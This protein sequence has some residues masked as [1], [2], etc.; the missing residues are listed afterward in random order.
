[1]I[2]S[3]WWSVFACIRPLSPGPD[4]G[5]CAET[6]TGVFRYGEP[7]IGTCLA[8]PSELQFFGQDGG[9]FLAV[10]NTDPYRN[11]RS[12]SVL[13]LDWDDLAARIDGGTD[14][15]IPMDELRSYPLEIRQDDD[16]DGYADNPFLGGFA[17]LPGS[18]IAVV[19]SRLSENGVLR[20]GR[21]EA[22]LL[23]L[24]RMELPGG[25]LEVAGTLRLEDDPMPAVADPAT[26][27]VFVGNL[28]D[29]S[30]SVLSS[31]TDGPLPLVEIDVAPE[32]GAGPAR[33]TDADGDGS[34]AEMTRLAVAT[35]EDLKD[36]AF[37]LTYVD[38]TSRL[39]VPT[40]V[41]G[42]EEVVGLRR[43]TSGG[44]PF[45]PT[46]FGLD[47]FY[48]DTGENGFGGTIGEPFVEVDEAGL[49][50]LWFSRPDGTIWRALQST[51]AGTWVVEATAVRSFGGVHRAPSAAPLDEGVGL[52]TER[53]GADGA[54]EIW[55]AVAPDGVSFS[56]E[57]AVL[58]PPP[59]VSFEQPFAVYDASVQRWRMWLTVHDGDAFSV[60]LSES[61]DGRTWS[62]P[63]EVLRE[64]RPVA[65]PTVA[66]LDGRY[67]M[68]TTTGPGDG[69]WSHA[70]S[71]SYD[72]VAWTSPEVVAPSDVVADRP[73]RAGAQTQVT[74]AWRLTAD[75][76]GSLDALLPAGL[77]APVELVGLELMVSSGHEVANRAS[78]GARPPPV[79]SARSAQTDGRGGHRVYATAYDAAGKGRVV[80]F[81]VDDPG[82][83]EAGDER[84]AWS[85]LVDGTDLRADLDLK[86]A[87]T[88]TDPV[89]V[90]D[91]DGWV[92]FATLNDRS[93]ARIVRLDTDD[94]LTFGPLD[95][96]PVIRGDSDGGWD[97]AGQ[98][99]A[100]VE[101]RG[102]EIHLWY[103]GDDG[104]RR[105][106][107]S[108]VAPTLRD[109]FVRERGLSDE[110][111]F[112]TGLPGS[113]DDTSVA[114]PLV[115]RVGEEVHLWYSG[116]D[117]LSWH[118][119]H[120]V[121]DRRGQ[122]QRRI[123]PASQLSVPAM[124]GQPRSF[125]SL[126]VR[127]PVLLSQDEGG[128]VLLYTG[129][130]G[131]GERIGRARVPAV[132]PDVAFAAQRFPT[133][134]DTLSFVSTRGGRGAQVIELNQTTQWYTSSAVGFS[135]LTH[136]PDRGFLYVTSKLLDDIEVVDVRDDSTGAWVD[137]NAFDLETVIRLDSGGSGA[138]FRD[139]IV[140]RTRSLLYL[141][142]RAPDALVAVDLHLVSDDDSKAPT[143]RAVVGVL[144]LPS[145]LEDLGATTLA[146]FGGADMAM[147]AD[148]HLLLVPHFRQNGVSVFDLD[149]GAIGAEIAWIPWVGENP[150]AARISPDQRYAVV[151]N[152]VGSVVDSR[153]ESSLAVIDLDPASDTFLEVVAWLVNR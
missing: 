17:Y 85:V 102:G 124:D 12:G 53:V 99:A 38:A 59:G 29:H 87:E 98:F 36:D 147:T 127:A 83:A 60:G 54:G 89:A 35:V 139:G 73:P 122:F 121:R 76:G 92:V 93:G 40:P 80:V 112:G 49:A 15:R 131:L 86:P 44:G 119:G 27:L 103:T 74:G 1:M 8:G 123:D 41:E 138:G 133:A 134:G 137:D 13:V 149:Q 136:D 129:R 146:Q 16:G 107:G 50:T 81:A 9:N 19:P 148:E 111:A 91:G 64:R 45:E 51:L 140:S 14:R 24:S 82:R 128:L 66:R 43:W 75:D 109:R 46:A 97:A 62:D 42:A 105:T 28:T 104:S 118:L 143:D 88:V 141:T 18:Q 142:Q 30:V 106:I 151:A 120:A 56:D 6:P 125:S 94:G 52:Y 117:G 55:L 34:F 110:Y 69:T 25:G 65:A 31:D 7:G 11:F 132:A 101:V 72:G 70:W 115:V 61:D 153:V 68:W 23:D 96:T 113:F 130:D 58:V 63:V 145:S 21:D 77:D 10:V 32:A 114:D 135:S 100:S 95:R 78:G 39:F 33:L 116:F 71:W 4:L 108:A 47:E 48:D 22:Y 26:G 90:R 126:G 5:A 84:S 57:G 152:Y 144:P 37:T 150:I 79:V 3:L 2:P 20:T 67:V